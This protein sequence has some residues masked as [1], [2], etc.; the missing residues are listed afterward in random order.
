MRDAFDTDLSGLGSQWKPDDQDILD[1]QRI[2]T[3]RD[4]LNQNNYGIAS[5]EMHPESVQLMKQGLEPKRKADQVWVTN[6]P[7]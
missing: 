5:L 6:T 4:F 7:R 3:A 1:E 2:F